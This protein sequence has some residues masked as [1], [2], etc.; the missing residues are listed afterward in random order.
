MQGKVANAQQQH[1][2]R[3]ERCRM[4]ITLPFH[5]K[6]R[7]NVYHKEIWRRIS[8]VTH[9]RGHAIELQ[10]KKSFFGI[11]AKMSKPVISFLM[12]VNE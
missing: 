9:L 10:K 4:L 7:H 6:Q 5:L 3:Q 12:R 11:K 2:T 1:T 8:R